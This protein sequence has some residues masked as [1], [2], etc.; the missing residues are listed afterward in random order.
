MRPSR[1]TSAPCPVG[2][3]VRPDRH[4]DLGV[5]AARARREP[6]QARRRDP[7]RGAAARHFGRGGR[8]ASRRAGRRERRSADP[9]AG[10]FQLRHRP[11]AGRGLRLPRRGR[12][13]G[14]GRALRVLH[15]RSR[16]GTRSASRRSTGCSAST[17]SR[18]RRCARSAS[19][20]PTSW[21][22]T[23]EPA[24][25][26]CCATRRGSSA[27]RPRPARK[28]PGS[29][30]GPRASP[31]SRPS[32]RSARRGSHAA[33]WNP[34]ADFLR[35][36]ATGLSIHCHR[37]DTRHAVT[38]AAGRRAP[39]GLRADPRR[40]AGR[41]GLRYRALSRQVVRNRPAGPSL[42]ARPDEHHGHLHRA[43]RRLD[44]RAEPGLRPGEGRVAAGGGPREAR[45]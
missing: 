4:R 9:G 34:P 40:R 21:S 31:A 3:A 30:R 8:R 33:F 15:A 10:E 26:S 6:V 44:R 23:S 39:C 16:R 29:R 36:C 25:T 24:P 28:W 45:R 14:D 35:S 11:A 37:I 5:R 17:A 32:R 13:A 7:R 12:V 20:S 42:R 19:C 27:S 38:R 41:R 2:R 18:S 43:R 1:P 22:P